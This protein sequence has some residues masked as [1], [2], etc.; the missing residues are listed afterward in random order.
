[1]VVGIHLKVLIGKSA[2]NA[3]KKDES[4]VKLCVIVDKRITQGAEK[5]VT[6]E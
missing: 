2:S 1:V 5:L 3:L 6:P 4:N